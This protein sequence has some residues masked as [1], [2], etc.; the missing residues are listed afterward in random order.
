[1]RPLLHLIYPPLCL[2]C[3][4][5]L[6]K[7]KTLF[8]TE[9]LGQLS[10]IEP[11]ERCP[12]CFAE[13]SSKC[14]RCKARRVVI[15]RQAAAC[16]CFG[17]ARTLL[18]T[19]KKGNIEWLDSAVSLMA[20]QYVTLDWPRPDLIIPLPFSRFETSRRELSFL[21][22]KKLAVLLGCPWAA[23][24]SASFDRR[25]FLERGAFQQRYSLQK[26]R[27]KMENCL[28]ILLVALEL[29]DAHLRAAAE[30]LQEGFPQEISALA[31]VSE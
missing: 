29:D 18:A 23:L 17:P 7:K 22:A 2:H 26:K 1:M 13:K 8:C 5:C 31:F 12:I 14:L 9:C 28:R 3:E 6:E 19:L 15:K 10:L 21:L 20:L 24:L 16:A 25:A 30:A 11:Q 4:A 27:I